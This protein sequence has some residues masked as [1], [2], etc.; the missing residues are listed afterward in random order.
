MIFIQM[1]FML[2]NKVE[3]FLNQIDFLHEALLLGNL[4]VLVGSGS[5]DFALFDL[6]LQL[7]DLADLLC[8]ILREI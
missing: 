5:L 3:L 1:S 7:L 8:Q 6:L 2:L 4:V